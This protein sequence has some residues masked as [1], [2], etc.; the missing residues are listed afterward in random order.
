MAATTTPAETITPRSAGSPSSEGE[1]HTDSLA[2][3]QVELAEVSEELEDLQETAD[4]AI[5]AYV[6]ELEHLDEATESLEGAETASTL[7]RARYDDTRTETVQ[8]AISAYQGTELDL[9]QAWLDAEGPED[10]LA[11][12][13]HLTVLSNAQEATVD[14]TRAS[15]VAADTVRDRARDAEEEQRAAADDAEEAKDAALAA[16]AEQEEIK[17][18]LLA[19]RTEIENRLAE[20]RDDDQNAALEHQRETAQ[21]QA[22]SASE[23]D[24]A[25]P[26]RTTPDL[27]VAREGDGT[28]SS[29]TAA[30]SPETTVVPDERSECTGGDAEAHPNGQLPDS[31]LCPLPQGGERL[32]ADAAAAFI[33]LD[34]AFRAEFGRPMCVADSYRPFDTQLRLF[35]ELEEGMAAPPGTSVHGAG[36]AVD[37]CGGVEDESSPEHAWMRD[38]GPDF[39]WHHPDWAQDGFEPWHWEFDSD[40][41]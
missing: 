37:L 25:T 40:E 35:H 24:G 2:S 3:L 5:R 38:H 12:S 14:R 6:T 21:E 29:D 20:A 18:D 13:A 10:V 39:G 19:E 33:D 34:G 11:R 28:T 1:D 32:R 26:A 4:D 17:G 23:G 22:D 16:V 30:D 41:A 31:V 15:R 8:Y 36:L 27:E 7:A 9:A